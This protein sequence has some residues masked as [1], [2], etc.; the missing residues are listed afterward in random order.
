[1]PHILNRSDGAPEPDGPASIDGS[2]DGGG[3]V[4]EGVGEVGGMVVLGVSGP[5][6]QPRG[7]MEILTEI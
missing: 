6:G 4:R 2:A 7:P 1:L 3:T 5:W